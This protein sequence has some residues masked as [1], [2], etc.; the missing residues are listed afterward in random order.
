MDKSKSMI[1]DRVGMKIGACESAELCVERMER[2]EQINHTVS[3]P[4][5]PPGGCNDQNIN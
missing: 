2:S 1:G 3:A 4:V 5:P